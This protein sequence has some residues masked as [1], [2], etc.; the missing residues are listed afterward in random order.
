[1]G[2][3]GDAMKEPKEFNVKDFVSSKNLNSL[4]EGEQ[5]LIPKNHTL[6]E[7]E[8]VIECVDVPFTN[9]FLNYLNQINAEL[10]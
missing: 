8:N 4:P 2:S 6:E 5:T 1:M 10:C 3:R 7:W 9:E